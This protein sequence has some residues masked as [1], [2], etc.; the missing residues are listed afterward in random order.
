MQLLLVEK[1]AADTADTADI[2]ML[3][4]LSNDNYIH[5]PLI[6]GNPAYTSQGNSAY[7][8][9][10]NTPAGNTAYTP[11]GN[12]AY[13][14]PVKPRLESRN[15][16]AVPA[17]KWTKDSLSKNTSELIVALS[18]GRFCLLKQCHKNQ[19]GDEAK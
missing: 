1:P 10:G 15:K 4:P 9:P 19:P 3:H 5:A 18:L 7:T 2:A 13:T 6:T 8:P 14:P 12:T 17:R 16:P 11:P